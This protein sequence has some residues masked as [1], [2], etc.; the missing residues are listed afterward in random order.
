[1]AEAD[2]VVATRDGRER[3][4][5]LDASPLADVTQRWFARFA[6]LW[7]ETLANLE[8]RGAD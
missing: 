5:S 1:V 8:R 6:P 3:R 2:V 7:E 4:C